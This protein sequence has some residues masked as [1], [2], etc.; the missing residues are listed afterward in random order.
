MRGEAASTPKASVSGMSPFSSWKAAATSKI[1][2]TINNVTTT[3]ATVQSDRVKNGP[4]Q[5]SFLVQIKE[6]WLHD[7]ALRREEES[8]GHQRIA[9]FPGWATKRYSIPSFP[10]APESSFTVEVFVSGYAYSLRPPESASRSQKAFMKLAKGFATLPKVP[11]D[12]E[13]L[14][15]ART[16]RVPKL[17]K[18]TE[19]LLRLVELPPTPE[20]IN[21]EIE[22][23]IL[24]SRSVLSDL[25]EPPRPHFAIRSDT[26]PP[27]DTSP[28]TDDAPVTNPNLYKHRASS[29]SSLSSTSSSCS[30]S[31]GGSPTT[32]SP[33]ASF[34]G[35]APQELIRLHA[36]FD[37]RLQPF[38]GSIVTNRMVRITLFTTVVSGH[39][40]DHGHGPLGTIDVPLTDQGYF[41]HLFH[42]P[43]DT[44]CTHPGGVHIAFGDSS[45]EHSLIAF[46]E[47]LPPPQDTFPAQ[48]PR[49]LND[50]RPAVQSA[51]HSTAP[52]AQIPIPIT[53]ARVR[54]ISDIDDTIKI[55]HILH[56]VR[57][58]FR[59]VF[60]RHLEELSV[61]GMA[62]WY[63]TL[64]DRGVRFHYVSNSPFELLPVLSDFFRVGGFPG[65]SLKLK[66]YGGKSLF[67]GLW[68]PAGERKKAGVLEVLDRFPESKFILVGDSGEQDLELYTSLAKDF[69]LR[70][71]D[72]ILGIFIRDVL[73]D[74]TTSPDTL[75]L[76]SP[77]PP[78]PASEQIPGSSYFS[79]NIPQSQS[80]NS[81]SFGLDS[82]L[83]T[84][85]GTGL[86]RNATVRVSQQP[87]KQSPPPPR[88]GTGSN[89]SRHGTITQQTLSH[90]PHSPH[91]QSS[92]DSTMS[93]SSW[94]SHA[95]SFYTQN[96]VNRP[97]ATLQKKRTELDA[98]IARAVSGLPEHVVFRLFK[99]PEEC[100]A[101]A[102]RLINS[103]LGD[104]KS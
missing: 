100:K 4:R 19:E 60:V 99:E 3:L 44:V 63:T 27:P 61:P 2:G 32:L 11:L 40:P 72:Q 103:V 96:Q 41:G 59:N 50:F 30:T 62:E 91:P 69:H 17:S 43:Y 92:V 8:K 42:I 86:D 49:N 37:S 29:T 85:N 18:S 34:A 46:A 55:S 104:A 21:D 66:F 52:K 78:S 76:F 79:P 35:M 56:G 101:E 87:G 93:V 36:N 70:G 25:L 65:G 84:S 22:K 80:P 45:S 7:R 81:D 89:I 13:G 90:Q 54:L 51:L 71:R 6:Q 75:P 5:G 73:P 58:V 88:Q 102:D 14:P 38:W 53:N 12:V 16:Y 95:G 26:E 94:V 48:F 97:N 83:A 23:S 68:E 57:T 39:H 9:L 20:G 33:A 31:S 15:T 74:L 77:R 47:L 1:K 10:R 67:K 28:W 24:E 64:S 98:R 82:D